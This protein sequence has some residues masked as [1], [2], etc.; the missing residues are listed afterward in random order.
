MVNLVHSSRNRALEARAIDL[1]VPV[2]LIQVGIVLADAFGGL[3][4]AVEELTPTRV[5]V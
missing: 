4:Q 2:G 1:V 3:A 5:G